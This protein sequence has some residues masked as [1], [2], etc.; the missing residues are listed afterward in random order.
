MEGRYEMYDYEE[1]R[2]EPTLAD[3]IMVEYQRK[4]KDALLE[5]VKRDIESVKNENERLKEENG[6]LQELVYGIQQ[7][8]NSLEIE[9]SQFQRKLRCE[10]LSELMGDFEVVMY[11]VDYDVVPIPKCNKCD[12]KRKIKFTSP[13]GKEMEEYCT[14]D[15]SNRVYGVKELHCYEFKIDRDNRTMS[16]WYK[17]LE[18]NDKEYGSYLNSD[19]N[20][21]DRSSVYVYQNGNNF[22]DI[23]VEYYSIY[24]R[25]E[26]QCQKYCD[27]LNSK[28]VS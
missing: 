23:S 22:E 2:Y 25:S 28:E 13:L 11:G 27:W 14:C 18:Y 24:F 6:K 26:A 19:G 15:V 7:R 12:N 8:E 16:L 3:E 9:K 10:R 20:F 5:S 1:P 17:K 21:A 4:M